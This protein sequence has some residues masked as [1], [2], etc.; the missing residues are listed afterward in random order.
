MYYIC[1]NDAGSRG[2]RAGAVNCL[3]VLWMDLL[4]SKHFVLHGP[5]LNP[6]AVI[7]SECKMMYYICSNDA[8]SRGVRAGS[9]N[10][11]CVLWME[12]L[13]SKHFVLHGPFWNSQ[14]V[15]RSECRMMYE[16]V[17]QCTNGVAA[18]CVSRMD[19]VLMVYWW[20][21]SQDIQN[22]KIHSTSSLLGLLKL[23]VRKTIS[24]E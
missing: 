24:T 4:A 21:Y 16:N 11:L 20:T 13:A 1:S 3:S 15:I 7:R 23:A 14:A 19:H 9:A 10:C 2:V 5:F 6:Q 17:L 22:H 8:G 18:G 12:L